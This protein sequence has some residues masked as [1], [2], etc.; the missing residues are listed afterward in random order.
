MSVNRFLKFCYHCKNQARTFENIPCINCY[1]QQN[2][3]PKFYE[4]GIPQKYKNYQ[5]DE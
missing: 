2:K 5:Q 1:M 3:K 4:N